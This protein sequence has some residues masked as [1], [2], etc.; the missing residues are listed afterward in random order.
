MAHSAVQARIDGVDRLDMRAA[1]VWVVD[2]VVAL[3]IRSCGRAD[4]A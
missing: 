2:I 4:L 3:Q 1:Q